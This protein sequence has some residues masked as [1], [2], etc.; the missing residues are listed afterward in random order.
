VRTRIARSWTAAL[1]ACAGLASGLTAAEARGTVVREIAKGEKIRVLKSSTR[2]ATP[3]KLASGPDTL[4]FRFNS[5][6]LLTVT[7]VTGSVDV[8]I[9]AGAKEY[10]TTL[11]RGQEVTVW[12]LADI[13]ASAGVGLSV[14]LNMS[15]WAFAF[16]AD[17][18]G[19]L[20]L[21]LKTEDGESLLYDGQRVDSVRSPTG[22]IELARSTA[23]PRPI[24]RRAPR[25]R[26]E[27]EPEYETGEGDPERPGPPPHAG[28]RGS[29]GRSAGV[30]GATIVLPEPAPE[31]MRPNFVSP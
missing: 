5:A 29:L 31:V 24:V 22:E 21:L 16:R 15:S 20:G 25:S 9:R 28:R 26:R 19:A 7:R 12:A 1:V 18:A 3:M 4:T 6:G 23:R 11:S 10:R 13:T 8:V 17:R 27:P 14:E 30:P 2:R